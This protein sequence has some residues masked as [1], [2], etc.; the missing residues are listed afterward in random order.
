[1]VCFSDYTLDVP[2]KDLDKFVTHILQKIYSFNDSDLWFLNPGE[3]SLNKSRTVDLVGE[4]DT[5]YN[6]KFRKCNFTTIVNILP[7]TIRCPGK[8]FYSDAAVVEAA[9]KCIHNETY[10]ACTDICLISKQIPIKVDIE[11]MDML[12]YQLANNGVITKFFPLDKKG[13]FVFVSNNIPL[14]FYNID[15]VLYIHTVNFFIFD[16]DDGFNGCNTKNAKNL[17]NLFRDWKKVCEKD[18]SA[19]FLLP[20]D[21]NKL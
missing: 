7:E 5:H 4:T 2:K 17:N 12:M 9:T 21:L 3:L 19:P 20:N 18:Y 14:E 6:I 16:F 10:S 15:G 13:S 11:N 1:M 8:T